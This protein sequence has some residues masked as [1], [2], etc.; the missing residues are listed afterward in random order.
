MSFLSLSVYPLCTRA[1]K[2]PIKLTPTALAAFSSVSAILT[3]PSTSLLE[4]NP[5]GVTE[6]LLLTIG[7]PY[8]FSISHA[9]LTR[10]PALVVILS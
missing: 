7:I 4:I 2:P 3:Q 8:S 1:E 6:I 5:I 10:L 9:V